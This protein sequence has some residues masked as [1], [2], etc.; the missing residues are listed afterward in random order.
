MKFLLFA[1]RQSPLLTGVT[2]LVGAL[3]GMSGAASIALINAQLEPSGPPPW[4]S[5]QNFAAV[6]ALIFLTGYLSRVLMARLV[7]GTSFKLR[8]NLCRRVLATPLRQTE[9]SGSKI[10][11]ALT[12]DVNS[13]TNALTVLPRQCI[14]ATI[15]LGCLGYLFWLS[16]QVMGILTLFLIVA[17]LSVKLPE[18]PAIRLMG[19][20]RGHWDAMVKS[21]EALVGGIKELQL[22]RE[23]RRRFYTHSLEA[24]AD[25]YRENLARSLG[26]YALTNSWTQVLYFLFI[27]ILIF[28][29][30]ASFGIEASTL[31]GF[32]LTL[33]YMYGPLVQLADSMP[34]YSRARVALGKLNAL[35]LDVA[36]FS[37]EEGEEPLEKLS[38]HRIELVDLEHSYYR[39]REER[40]FVLGPISLSFEVGEVV[41]LVG[42]NG[43][44]KTTFA[45]LLSGLYAPD[46]G[47]IRL[48]GV[49]IDEGNREAYRQCFSAVF[50]EFHL[51]Q[52][53]LGL[54]TTESDLDEQV[55]AYLTQLQLDHKVEVE[56]GV[57]S[58]TELSTGQR[59]RLALL[60][61]YLEDRPVYI[62]DE[63][64]ADQDPEFKEIFYRMLVPELKAR[65]KLVIVIS[66]DDRYFDGADRIIQLEYGKLL[67]GRLRAAEEEPVQPSVG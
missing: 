27:G 24:S 15:V 53:L 14:N 67:D 5:A 22:N 57:L 25:A 35:G 11:A 61:T 37:A 63:W 64:A 26:I 47:E 42:G 62:F 66:H 46:G 17:L 7:F 34:I 40:H 31:L 43:S 20:S 2:I 49:P 29:F 59:K 44:G 12:D 16:P 9:Q 28:R 50:A 23:R 21:F 48:D 6:V 33:V 19:I 65:G 3:G 30:P 41:F 32:T 45:K 60:A 4:A 55:R 51:F 18:R 39:E 38:C 52:E 36:T 58:T 56:N 8:M 13:L 10:F 1:W 54:G